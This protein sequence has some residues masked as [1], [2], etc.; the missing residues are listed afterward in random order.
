MGGFGSGAEPRSWRFT[1]T[2]VHSL[3]IRG[4]KQ[5]DLFPELDRPLGRSFALPTELEIVAL[6]NGGYD[7]RVWVGTRTRYGWG[8]AANQIAR[9][10]WLSETSMFIPI[11]CTYPHLGGRRFWFLCPRLQCERRCLV[12][13]RERGTNAR[14]FACRTCCRL[15]YPT[16]RMS[17]RDRLDAK[18]EKYAAKLIQTSEGELRRPKW[19]RQKTFERAARHVITLDRAADHACL[20]RYAGLSSELATLRRKAERLAH[21]RS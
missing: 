12:L 17:T 6:E 9:T 21:S 18:A 14:A 15:A 19:M 8:V 11:V 1:T 13:Y 16:Q 4:L 10:R 2:E 7:A 5:F 3:D 20:G